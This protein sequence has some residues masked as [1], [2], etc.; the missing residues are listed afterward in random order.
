MFLAAFPLAFGIGFCARGLVDTRTR[1]IPVHDQL[2]ADDGD[3]VRRAQDPEIRHE[4]LPAESTP[5]AVEPSDAPAT[6][7][8]RTGEGHSQVPEASKEEARQLPASVAIAA[9]SEPVSPFSLKTAVPVRQI[10][11]EVVQPENAWFAAVTDG[12]ACDTGTCRVAPQS[13]DRKLNTAL[14]W[15]PTPEAAAAEA[16]REGKLVFLIHVSGNFAQPGFT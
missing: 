10:S 1:V 13:L 6:A 12:A 5:A 4:K 15:T 2:A 9:A 16:E 8:S 14:V 3:G 7:A 11:A